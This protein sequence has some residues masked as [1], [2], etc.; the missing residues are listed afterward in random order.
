MSYIPGPNLEPVKAILSGWPTL[1][2]FVL[3]DLIKSFT[4]DSKISLLTS[5]KDLILFE[6]FKFIFLKFYL[7]ILDHL[8]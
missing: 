6:N 2:K 5:F 4:I 7:L 1:L 8:Y 3:C